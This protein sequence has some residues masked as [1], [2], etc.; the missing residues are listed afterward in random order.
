MGLK[1]LRELRVKIV[2]RLVIFKFTEKLD[3][4]QFNLNKANRSVKSIL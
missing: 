2:K 4:K 1:R 3:L